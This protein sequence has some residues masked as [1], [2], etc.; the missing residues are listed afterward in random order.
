VRDLGVAGA[1]QM[2]ICADAPSNR[3]ESNVIA[4]GRARRLVR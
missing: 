4:R 3:E 1:L 2:G